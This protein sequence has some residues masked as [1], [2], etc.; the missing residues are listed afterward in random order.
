VFYNP[1]AAPIPSPA[2]GGQTV[3]VL[4]AAVPEP[5]AWLLLT[6]GGLIAGRIVARARE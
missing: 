3:P 1:A 4:S 5:A 6:L 2:S